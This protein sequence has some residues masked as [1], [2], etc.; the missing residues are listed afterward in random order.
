MKKSKNIVKE[1]A[2]PKTYKFEDTPTLLTQVEPTYNGKV[3]KNRYF[4][5]EQIEKSYYERQ[6]DCN[7]C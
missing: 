1:K 6:K 7:L 3:I 2:L 4:L 5:L